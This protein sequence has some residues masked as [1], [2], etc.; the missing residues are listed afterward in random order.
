MKNRVVILFALA[1]A[2]TFTQSCKK[3]NLTSS[4][5]NNIISTS[6]SPVPDNYFQSLNASNGFSDRVTIVNETIIIE[7]NTDSD[8]LGSGQ[9]DTRDGV[10]NSDYYWLH[11]AEVEPF[12]LD[13]VTLSATHIAFLDDKAYISYHRRGVEH[14]GALEV[15][16]LSDPNNPV[17]IY[18]GNFNSADINSIEV[19]KLPGSSD[20][21]IWLSLSDSKKGAVLGVVT[22]AGGTTYSGIEIVNLS[23]FIDGGI[24]SSANSVTYSGDYLYVSSGKTHGGAFCINAETLEVLGSVEFENGKYIEVNGTPENATKVVSLQTGA[25][26]SLRVEDI[27]SFHFSNEYN[28]GEIL[29]QNVD[30]DS[31]GKSTIHFVNNDPDN[32]YITKGKHGLASYNIH[33]GAETWSSSDAMLTT[34]NT[35]GVTSDDEFIYAANGA[36]GLAVFTKPEFP[37]IAP[38]LVFTWD[39]NEPNPAPANFI[40]VDGS[41][42]WIL[43]AK[44]L[45]GTKILRRPQPGDYLPISGFNTQGVPN[46]VQQ[47]EICDALLSNIISLALP[48]GQNAMAAHPEYFDNSVPYNI[49]IEEDAEVS[50]SFINEG[51]GYKNVLGYYY[52]NADN[53]PTSVDDIIKLIAFPNASAQGSGGGLFEGSTVSLYGNF[54]ANTVIGFF[55]NSNGWNAGTGTISEGLAAHYSDPAFNANGRQSVI[56]YEPLCEELVVCFDDQVVGSGDNDFNDAIFQL[57]VHPAS[58]VDITAYPTVNASSPPPNTQNNIAQ[59]KTA[60]QSSLYS[61][62]Q[63]LASEAI[64]GITGGQNFNHTKKNQNAWWEVDL[65]EVYDL[66]AIN[67]FNRAN[68]CQSRLNDFHVL[69]SDVPFNSTDL[70]QTINQP[71]V[72]DFHFTGSAQDLTEINLNRQGRYVRV[73]LSGKNY[74]HLSEV[75]IFN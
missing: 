28:V 16:D 62:S 37:G 5:S 55:L 11:V 52:Y 15:V 41:T 61:N 71:G 20:V 48:N 36:D 40:E 66:S 39:M 69:V 4:D 10:T 64:D 68:C 74:L 2:L 59:G 70:N 17:V 46:N 35:N 22:M 72:S 65:E 23:K 67:V 19:G 13:G 14:L 50:I 43:I 26:S 30:T 18:R 24:S 56:L 29:H 38:E 58:A 12:V 57:N 60:T 51:A 6:T 3:D 44:G 54:K 75:Q 1:T 8:S 21:K 33:T 32:V 7:N 45:G 25:S 73:Q 53:P 34:G 63:F 42:E 49:L 27:G 31:R 47:I 9:V